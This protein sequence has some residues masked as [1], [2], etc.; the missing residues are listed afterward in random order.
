MNFKISNLKIKIYKTKYPLDFLCIPK[1][2]F[3]FVKS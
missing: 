1:K 2:S 3:T